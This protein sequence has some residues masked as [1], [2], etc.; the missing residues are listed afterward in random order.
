M[1]VY[2]PPACAGGFFISTLALL[3]MVW[4]SLDEQQGNTTKGHHTMRDSEL[5]NEPASNRLGKSTEVE[6]DTITQNNILAAE[7]SKRFAP[8]RSLDAIFFEHMGSKIYFLN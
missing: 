3:T 4:Y 5:T 6:W 2:P 8:H 7:A 1:S